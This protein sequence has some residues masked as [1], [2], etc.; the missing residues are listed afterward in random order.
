MF[1]FTT[2]QNASDFIIKHEFIQEQ[3]LKQLS[4]LDNLSLNFQHGYIDLEMWNDPEKD[5][6]TLE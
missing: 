3:D 6:A 1:E 5:K 4:T 2:R